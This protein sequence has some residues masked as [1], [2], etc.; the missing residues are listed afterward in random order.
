[1]LSIKRNEIELLIAFFLVSFVIVLLFNVIQQAHVNGVAY[2]FSSDGGEYYRLYVLYSSS[3]FTYFEKARLL[4]TGVPVLLLL[5]FDGNVVPV[6]LLCNVIFALSLMIY[7]RTVRLRN[8]FWFIVI[9]IMPPVSF[10]LFAVNKEILLVSGT[11]LFISYYI[12]GS[13]RVLFF[14][15]VVMFMCRSYMAVFFIYV[16]FVIPRSSMKIHYFRILFSMIIITILAPY[17]LLSGGFG[18]DQNLLDNAGYIAHFFADEIRNGFYI[19]LY[20]PKYLYLMLIKVWGLYMD[21]LF[22]GNKSILRDFL[23]SIYSFSVMLFAV[24]S[25]H[26]RKSYPFRFLVLGFLSSYPL[27]FSD[28]VHW[29]YYIFSLLFFITYLVLNKDWSVGRN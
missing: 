14:S 26:K 4:I 3:E 13:K 11:L 6:L 5:L 28:I 25:R 23:T 22:G 20:I 7:G 21:G 27:M 1:M 16:L 18:T 17:V 15:I 29:R 2:W 12:S 8:S 24:L 10:G 9:A 19:F